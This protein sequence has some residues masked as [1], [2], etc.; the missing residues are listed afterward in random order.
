MIKDLVK[1]SEQQRLELEVSDKVREKLIEE[2]Y[3]P[4]YGAR[5][6]RRAVMRLVEDKIASKFLEEAPEDKVRIFVDMDPFGEV[7]VS[8][9]PL[10]NPQINSL[11][12]NDII[13]NK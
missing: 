3:N 7:I 5:P 1:R 11:K 4:A 9:G 2:G 13:F 6:L 10:Q 8:F 12:E